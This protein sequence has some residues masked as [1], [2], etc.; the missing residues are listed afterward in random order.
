MASFYFSDHLGGNASC[1][2]GI[3]NNNNCVLKIGSFNC[4]GLNEY[5]KRIA[6]FDFFKSTDLSIIFLQETKLKPENEWDYVREW[7]NN[8]C[9]FNSCPGGK[10]GTA[11][12]FNSNSIH[13]LSNKL[14]DVEGR[15]IAVDVEYFGQV[16]HLVNSYGPNDYQLKI[17][18]LNRLYCYLGTGRNLIWCGDHNIATDCRLD[19]SPR[20]LSNDHGTTDFLQLLITFD[21]KD[22]CRALY[23]NREFFTYRRGSSRSRI[24]K[25]C[26]SSQFV[27]E[28]YCQ[29]ESLFSD[30]SLIYST[31]SFHSN[32][33]N[34]P[35]VWRNNIKYYGD[36]DLIQNLTLIWQ[37]CKNESS[38]TSNLQ[39]WWGDAKYKMKLA[40][41]QFS[42]QKAMFRKRSWQ[43]RDQALHNITIALRRNPNDKKLQK[44]Y[45]Q[46]KKHLVTTKIKEIKETILKSDAEYLMH[47]DKPTKSFFD[48]FKNRTEMHKI[49]SLRNEMGSEVHDI[50]DILRVA[51]NFYRQIFSGGEIHQDIVNLF[52][53]DISPN[54]SNHL[55]MTALLL[56]ITNEEIWEVIIHFK[57]ARSPGPD[58]LSIEFYRVMFPVIKDE[59]RKLLNSYMNNGRILSKFK[60]GIIK[61]VP[62]IPPYNEIGNFRPISLLNVDYKIFTKILSNR[63]QPILENLIHESQFCIPGKDINEMNNLVRDIL[64]EMQCSHSDSFFVSVDFRKA[65]DTISH[66]FLYQVLE[67]YGFPPTFISIIKEL[68]RD[69]GSHLLINGHKSK[70]IKLKSGTRQGDPISRDVFTLM[71]N[72]L[73][74][75]L[76]RLDL[77]SKYESRS[78]KKFL[79]LAFMDDV[80]FVTQSLSSLLNSVFYIRKFGK[81]SRLEIN[82][83]KSSGIFFN[84]TN[85]F[86]ISQLPNISWRE[87]LT[88][89]KI[90]YGPDRWVQAQ[91]NELLGRFRKE[92]VYLGTTAMT[93]RA[94]AIL[95]K[96]K[97]LAMMT[98]VCATLVMPDRIRASINKLVLKFI[99]PFCAIKSCSAEEIKGRISSFAAPKWLG[100][101]EI[102]YIT[103]HI[104]LL[105]LKPIMKY[106]KEL[107]AFQKVIS[108]GLFYVEFNIGMQL[109][110]FYN[111]SV[112]NSTTHAFSPSFVY[113]YIFKMIQ[114]FKI[115]LDELVNGTINSIYKRIIYDMNKRGK[116][117]SYRIF[118]KGLPSYLQ[119]FNYKLYKGILPV[120]T[121]FRE[122]GLDTDSRCSFCDIGPES[123]FH[124][125]GTCEKLKKVWEMLTEVW[126]V[127]ANQNFDFHHC[128]QNWQID[129]TSVIYSGVY[130]RPL[131]YLNSIINYGIW[132]MRNDIRFKFEKFD[133]KVLMRRVVRSI[134]ARKRVDS[135]LSPSFQIPHIDKLYESIVA[136]FNVFPFDNG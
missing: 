33:R 26:T 8:R 127:F 100:G 96:N 83:S 98:Y 24:D 121:M 32:F 107:N 79:T 128:R 2:G 92:I 10:S 62:K 130:E 55:L 46:I 3:V 37:S 82:L 23:P 94:K 44:E 125:F 6:L 134:G 38:L 35:G 129:L 1:D 51:E 123:I 43:M 19:R 64:D 85:V 135:K 42:K 61:L 36:D 14:I 114:F 80:N 18:F 68:F 93:M 72:P 115:T 17:P 69:A 111:V 117:K 77:I 124:L 120:K 67:R 132:K 71:L 57:L 11:I 81:A 70:K 25:I 22:N 87:E 39:K 21:L 58:G 9:I 4:Q 95:S 112:N 136:V 20:H 78:R 29:Q 48:K 66:E 75:F 15:V 34:G 103:L 119:S 110:H 53:R 74:V 50:H 63:L 13:V 106:F 109:C 102:D 88:V 84:K 52:L 126:L 73:L 40:F 41:I 16:F 99:A 27:V 104:D 133:H 56:P 91:W 47:G 49:T 30:H 54:E 86:T 97:L 45:S 76:N 31:I 65:F 131:I 122:Y 28:R 89:L 60:A 101:C 118:A 59:L 113:Q 5:Y 12:L 105:L 90:N 116:Y 108:P 7:H